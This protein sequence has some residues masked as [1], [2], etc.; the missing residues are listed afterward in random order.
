MI[1]RLIMPLRHHRGFPITHCDLGNPLLLS[2]LDDSF[3]D[4][5]LVDGE[6]LM[7]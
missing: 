6:K 2:F 3:E 4:E 1:R 7:A 5:V